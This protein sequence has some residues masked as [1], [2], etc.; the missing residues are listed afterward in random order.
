LRSRFHNLLG[1]GHESYTVLLALSLF[2]WHTYH[3]RGVDA[4]RVLKEVLVGSDWFKKRVVASILTYMDSCGYLYFKCQSPF[5]RP[6]GWRRCH[7]DWEVTVPGYARLQ[8]L[9]DNLG[10]RVED[11]LKQPDPHSVKKLLDERI[12]LLYREHWERVRRYEETVA[13]KFLV[14]ITTDKHYNHSTLQLDVGS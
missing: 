4:R 5:W 1:F 2:A 7:K 10:L 11:V 12:R 3:S 6:G 13:Q 14:E 9:L 8:Q